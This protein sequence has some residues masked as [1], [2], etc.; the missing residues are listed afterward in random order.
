MLIDIQQLSYHTP[1]RELLFG[2]VSSSL[3]RGEKAAIIGNNGAGKSTLLKIIAGLEPAFTGELKVNGSIRYVPQ[4]YGH[5]DHLTVG[6]VL[7]IGPLLQ[8]LQAIEKGATDQHYYDLLEDRWDLTARCGEAFARWGIAGIKLEQPLAQLSGG[9]KTRLFLSSIDIFQPDIVLLDEP[10]NHLDTTARKQLYE[11]IGNTN[12]TLLLTSHDRELLRLCQPIWE[13]KAAGINTYGGNYDHYAEQKETE[14]IALENKL[15]HYQ[16]TLRE[17]QVKQRETL[18][19]KQHTDAQGRKNS[20]HGGLP[21]GLINARRNNAEGSA[22][23][24]KIV[25]NAKVNELRS[26]LQEA[27]ALAQVAQL[28]KGYFGTPPLPAGKVLI[29]ATGINYGYDASNLL[30]QEP[31]SLTIRSG[32]RLAIHGDNGSG[33]TTLFKLLQGKLTPSQGTVQRANCT[34]L[35]LDQEYRLVD[36]G[37]TVLEQAL[38]FNEQLLEAAMVHTILAN[39]LFRP[40]EWNKPCSVLSGGEMLRLTLCCM[41]LQNRTPDI[42]FLDEPVNNLD[43]SNIQMLGKI[44]ADY[45]GTLIVISHDGG[46][47]QEVGITETL[48][49]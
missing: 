21:K 3:Q 26:Q 11:W 38:A 47:L 20:R 23:K 12:C 34:T 17:A 19:R 10:T 27:T 1:D 7:G 5:F 41:V 9:M 18:E 29:Q 49:L 37:K 45:R 40:P 22:G 13:L 8:A 44:F 25:H 2:N 6:E 16:K 31:L 48:Q 33:K 28:M 42:I 4:H 36:R 32:N 24:L 35:L 15:S 46:F 30:W 43:L 14:T 39:F